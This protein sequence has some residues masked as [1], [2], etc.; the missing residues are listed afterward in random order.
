V[1]PRASV[2]GLAGLHGGALKVRVAAPP[3][4]GAANEALVRF[5]AEQLG[6]ARSAVRVES[7]SAGRAKVIAVEGI[8]LETARRRLGL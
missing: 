8:D 1:Q 2:T 6:V 5:L 7:G 3:V 4:G